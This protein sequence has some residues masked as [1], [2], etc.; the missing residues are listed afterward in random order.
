[1]GLVDRVNAS[2]AARQRSSSP[3]SVDDWANYFNFGG[4]AYPIIQTTLGSVDRERVAL[5]AVGAYEASSPVFALVA[6]RMQVLSQ[7]RFQWTR[8]TGSQPGDLFGNQDLAILEKPWPGGCTADLL[9][10]V[11]VDVSLAGNC[12]LFRARKDRIARLRP[13]FVTIIL[14]SQIDAGHPADAPDV[15]VAA[16]LY[17]PPSGEQKVYFPAQVAH[18]APY[19]NPYYHFLGMSWLSPC[20]REIQGDVLSTDHKSRLFQNAATPNLAIK[21]DPSVG[22]DAVRKFKELVEE[23]H[24][25]TFNAWKCLAPETEVAMWDGR[26]LRA[27][28]VRAGDRVVAWEDGRPVPGEVSHT[29]LQPPSPIVT[30][31]TQRGRV[32]RTTAQH[33]FLARRVTSRRGRAGQVLGA[34]SWADAADLQ[35]GDLVR[36]G[37]GWARESEPADDSLTPYEAWVAGAI[38]G[39]G[40]TVSS[41]PV[42]S[43][44]DAGIRARLGIGYDLVPTGKGHD[45]RVRGVRSLIAGFGLMG[46]RAWE[47]R[48]PAQ[49][50]QASVKAQAA[51]LSGLIDTDGHITDPA[52]RRSAQVGITSTSP[53]LLRDVQHLL[54]GLGIN[55]SLSLPPSH[56][57][58]APC[59]GV[60]RRHD[61]WELLV[62]GNDQAALLADVLDLACASKAER[63]AE[64]A[65]RPSRQR[66][67]LYD[68]VVSVETGPPEPTIAIEVAG[69]HTHVTAGLVTHN[70]LYLGGGADP[71]TV[72]MNFQQL[73]YA[74]IQGKAESRLAAA[75]GVPPSWVGFSEGL[76]GSALNAGNFN[77]ARRRFSDGTC[78]HWWTNVAA[79]LETI[80]TPPAG[81][82]LWYDDRI[83]FMRQDAGDQ[84][85]IQQTQAATITALIRD[86]FTPESATK[87]VMDN[88]WSLLQHSGRISVQ[89]WEPGAESSAHP[90]PGAESP[91]VPA[92]APAVAP[93]GQ[94]ASSNG[95]SNGKAPS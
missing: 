46:K 63:L 36:T 83:P 11:E 61:A 10:R 72:G 14:G 84:A 37:L 8:M 28:E 68:R 73:D 70:T 30:V 6:A 39:D 35:P 57:A 89:L 65:S 9:A 38:T 79:S 23:E 43:A 82:N 19:P 29:G 77:S 80:V 95:S 76:Q 47:K 56:K 41:T 49:V 78:V 32:I 16:Y 33:P 93:S 34:E 25:G 24:T 75:A 58:D 60:G 59:A 20:I 42:I 85:S 71:V 48:I 86:G 18:I 51:F 64:Y 92:G 81:A 40:C 1:M 22:I 2:L 7:I 55:G 53:G 4:L 88:D 15:E 50:M 45:Y 17:T 31:R 12:Y 3:L 54:A 74:V 13:E 27:D 52:R 5:S 91:S 62:H 26:R 21:F 44:W 90:E 94:P 69:H 87:A 67:S 66:R